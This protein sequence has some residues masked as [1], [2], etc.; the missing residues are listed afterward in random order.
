MIKMASDMITIPK[1]IIFMIIQ[2]SIKKK[3]IEK[4]TF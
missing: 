2:K 3:L 1:M 4:T